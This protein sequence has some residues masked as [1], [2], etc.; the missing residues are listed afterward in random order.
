MID[1][2]REFVSFTV[3]YDSL[4]F[5]HSLFKR[6]FEHLMQEV[7]SIPNWFDKSSVRKTPTVLCLIHLM[8]EFGEN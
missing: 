5:N 3:N 6:L 8:Y 2:R 7:L 1:F 4:P